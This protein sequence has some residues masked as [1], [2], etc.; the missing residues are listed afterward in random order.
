MRVNVI[1]KKAYIS[2]TIKYTNDQ[3]TVKLWDSKNKNRFQSKVMK[4]KIPKH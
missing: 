1:Y 2:N 4:R 3:W